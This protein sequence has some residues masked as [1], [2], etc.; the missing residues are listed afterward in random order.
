[1][2]TNLN[3]RKHPRHR[4][5][6]S[7]INVRVDPRFHLLDVSESGLSFYSEVP[8]ESGRRLEINCDEFQSV[9]CEVVDCQ[10]EETDADL[11]EAAYRIRCRMRDLDAGRRMVYYYLKDTLGTAN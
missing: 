11:L 9:T 6:E 8:F 7:F 4:P 5:A 1:M 3:R 2:E 10:M